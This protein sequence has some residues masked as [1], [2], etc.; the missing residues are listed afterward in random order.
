MMIVFWLAVIA[1]VVFLI[2]YLMRNN[3]QQ[4]N[5]ERDQGDESALDILEKRYAN[6][7]LTREE[8]LE[9]KSDIEGR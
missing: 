3:A 1:G 6:G 9:M 4:N 5:Y 7:E 2:R 8:Y